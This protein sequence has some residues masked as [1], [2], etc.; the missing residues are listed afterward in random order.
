MKLDLFK[1]LLTQ[2]RRSFTIFF[3]FILISSTIQSGM[4]MKNRNSVFTSNSIATYEDFP[5][6][7][8]DKTA[9]EVYSTQL[10]KNSAILKTSFLEFSSQK[11]KSNTEIKDKKDKSFNDNFKNFKKLRK[12]SGK[13]Q[14]GNNASDWSSAEI[15]QNTE[16]FIEGVR[17][18][19]IKRIQNPLCSK[20]QKEENTEC[21]QKC[22]LIAN[23]LSNGIFKLENLTFNLIETELISTIL[24]EKISQITTLSFN[25]CA[26][27]TKTLIPSI[28][29]ALEHKDCKITTLS[30]IK[31]IGFNINN[32][33][34][35]LGSN[36]SVT[37]LILKDLKWHEF[38]SIDFRKVIL[39]GDN[40]R[41]IKNLTLSHC[42]LENYGVG[43]IIDYL[44]EKKVKLT[45]LDLSGNDIIMHE[46]SNILDAVKSSKGLDNL[47]K[48]NLS[49]SRF[50][51]EQFDKACADNEFFKEEPKGKS[52]TIIVV[53]D[54]SDKVA[55]ATKL[56][57]YSTLSL[58]ENNLGKEIVELKKITFEKEE[59]ELFRDVLKVNM[60]QI[61]S[62]SF[63][64]CRNES[65][66]L[67]PSIINALEHK[68]CKITTLDLSF[69]KGFKI[70]DIL[71]A[72]HS[73]KSVT[74]L[75]I[76]DLRENNKIIDIRKVIR[77]YLKNIKNL[78]LFQCSLTREEIMIIVNAL[79][80]KELLLTELDLGYNAI[81]K[82][83]LTHVLKAVYSIGNLSKL[84]LT[85]NSFSNKEFESACTEIGFNTVKPEGE[86]K[87]IIIVVSKDT[88]KEIKFYY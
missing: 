1:R 51:K 7:A 30:M 62:L 4:K 61:T 25:S 22:Y 39:V 76:K 86:S 72:L 70:N 16:K 43:R 81:N 65:D 84:N 27:K 37:N 13:K 34:E 47:D 53:I 6:D 23:S 2:N 33:L 40:F 35:A 11:Q 32:I 78:T 28:V 75:I 69:T 38:D 8:I 20:M 15:E 63:F 56:F 19:T 21:L 29:N 50:S 64:S 17:I 48:L 44:K 45:E 74:N 58:I 36:E 79:T 67:I 59:A 9:P 88:E 55:E 52:K 87:T 10:K 68:D 12:N 3:A 46:L 54:N 49:K 71:K 42:L 5:L 66:I 73:N 60:S 82:N 14:K 80:N 77:D 18:E 26:N 57:F 24:I 41:N 83:L 85:G 31:T